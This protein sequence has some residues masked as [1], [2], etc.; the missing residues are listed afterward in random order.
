MSEQDNE[1]REKIAK[2]LAWQDVRGR[3]EYKDKTP[4][5][6]WVTVVIEKIDDEYL[7]DATQILAIIKQAGYCIGYRDGCRAQADLIDKV[8]K[9]GG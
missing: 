8:L 3:I 9:K 2:L 1:T 6:V 7:E 5:Q 4:E